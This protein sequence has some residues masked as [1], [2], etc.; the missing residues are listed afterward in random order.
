MQ[1]IADHLRGATF[2]GA[3]GVIPSN[4]QQGYVMRRL[5]RRAI[6]FSLELNFT[7]NVCEQVVPI[8]TELYAPDYPEVAKQK[9]HLIELM[10]KEEKLFRQTLSA[11]VRHFEKTVRDE[12]SGETIFKLYD[13]YGFPVELSLEEAKKRNIKLASGWKG[14]F[15]MAIKQQRERSRTA[16]KGEFRGGLQ[17]TNPMH[18]KYHTATHIMYRA[19][20]QVLGDHVEQRGSNITEERT[21]FDFNHPEKLTPEQI[22]QVEDIV[23][24][25]IDDDLPVTWEEMPTKEALASG[26]RGHFGEKYGETSKVYIIGPKDKPFS[27]ELCGGP[28]VEHTGTLGEGGKHFKIVKEQS[29]SAGIRRI[30]A[31]L[32]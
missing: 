32:Q 14:A 20:R 6:R 27:M 2:L 29:S 13:T 25:V 18:I 8:I 26:A 12:L 7:F 3:D 9:Q 31:V 28:H 1:V 5:L 4:N 15:D 17:G 11:G 24:K 22:K 30:K 19:L 23:N 21:R 10:V 16:S